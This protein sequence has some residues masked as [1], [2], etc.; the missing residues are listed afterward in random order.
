MPKGNAVRVVRYVWNSLTPEQRGQMMG[1][2]GQ[3]FTANRTHT[4]RP[5]DEAGAVGIETAGNGN[6]PGAFTSPEDAKGSG[7]VA[8]SGVDP[9]AVQEY[10]ELEGPIDGVYHCGG[11]RIGLYSGLVPTGSQD[12]GVHS[13]VM[14]HYRVDEL[15][16]DQD[17]GV[18]DHEG[19]ALPVVVRRR[20]LYSYSVGITLGPPTGLQLLPIR[21]Y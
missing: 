8:P 19:N 6:A 5:Q 15:P 9:T 18:E 13:D 4:G 10:V 21:R 1:A 11:Y 17:F 12:I 2:I 20:G 14:R 3:R 7:F 16:A